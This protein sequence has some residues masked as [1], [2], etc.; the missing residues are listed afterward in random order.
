MRTCKFILLFVFLSSFSFL[1]ANSIYP[2]HNCIEPKTYGF[3]T[4]VFSVL[5]KKDIS[6]SNNVLYIRNIDKIEC[7][8]HFP[9]NPYKGLW[10]SSNQGE[11]TILS[12]Y[13]LDQTKKSLYKIFQVET[14]WLNIFSDIEMQDL[15]KDGINEILVKHDTFSSWGNPYDPG[16]VQWINIYKLKPLASL[17]TFYFI[18]FYTV[19]EIEIRKEI[20]IL[21][22]NSKKLLKKIEKMNDDD[23]P[24]ILEVKVQGNRENI[25]VYRKWLKQIENIKN[26]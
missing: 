10:I 8:E 17:S 13:Q 11:A 19:K 23:M 16:K 26:K 15:N 20:S 7:V 4:E 24:M 14:N 5:T 6:Y 12:F 2:N 22:E 18:D 3:T 25:S 9:N 1:F 21:E